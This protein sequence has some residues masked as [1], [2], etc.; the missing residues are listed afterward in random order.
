MPIQP[1]TQQLFPWL[2]GRTLRADPAGAT[3]DA[4]RQPVPTPAAAERSET[5]T[6]ASVVVD[7]LLDALDDAELAA[8]EELDT[9]DIEVLARQMQLRGHSRSHSRGFVDVT[10]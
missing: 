5:P 4:A 10:A 3:S 2:T 1:I 8:L 7:A 6:D 9:E